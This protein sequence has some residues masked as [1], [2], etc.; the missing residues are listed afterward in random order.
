MHLLCSLSFFAAHFDIYITAS[1]LPGIINVTVDYLSH[2]HTSKAFEATLTLAQHP[3][4]I[5]PL[6]FK[7][8]SP[9]TLDWT[10]PGF[11]QLFHDILSYI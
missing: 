9:H 10:S 8:I 11:L 7:L 2:G 3:T 1:H 6:P 5:P 4:A